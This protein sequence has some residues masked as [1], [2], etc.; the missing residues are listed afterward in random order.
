MNSIHYRFGF[1][2]K[3]VSYLKNKLLM[4]NIIVTTGIYDLLKDYVHRRKA[5]PKEAEIITN[6]LKNAIQVN[7]RD[8]PLD[9]VGINTIVTVHFKERDV[10]ETLHFTNPQYARNKHKTISI[11]SPIGVALVGRKKG[12]VIEWPFTNG[13]Q[14]MTILNIEKVLDK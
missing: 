8:L 2:R 5:N 11:I 14:T 13:T 10:E 6:E 1:V 4:S 12:D 3:Y 9:V 7:R